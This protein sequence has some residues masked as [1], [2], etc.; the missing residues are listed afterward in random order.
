MIAFCQPYPCTS[1]ERT[2]AVAYAEG[3]D[4]VRTATKA[5]S[6]RGIGF[7]PEAYP[8][9]PRGG[10]RFHNQKTYACTGEGPPVLAERCPHTRSIV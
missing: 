5:R 1:H 10:Q 2:R 8:V 6:D 9:D 4:T 7:M 3:V